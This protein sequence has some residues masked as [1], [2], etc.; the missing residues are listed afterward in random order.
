MVKRKSGA[1]RQSRS[2][3]TY[4]IGLGCWIFSGSVAHAQ[5]ESKLEE[6]EKR[7]DDMREEI[8]LEREFYEL[9][10]EGLGEQLDDLRAR[11]QSGKGANAFNPSITVFGN[12]LARADDRFVYLDD[13]PSAA[14]LDD[15]P[16]FR[17]LEVDFR[18]AIDPYS[19]AVV[20]LSVASEVPGEFSAG[21]EEAYV[22]LKRLP[23]LDSAPL[24]LKLRA[25]RFRPDFGRFNQ[26]HLHDLPQ[27]SY[28]RALGAYL[29]PEG[30]VGEGLG[31]NFFLPAGGEKNSLEADLQWL[32]G[33]GLPVADSQGGSQLA[34]LGHLKFFHELSDASTFELGSSLWRSDSDH[35]L[36]GVDATYKWK[37]LLQGESNSFLL[38]GELFRAQT[39]DDV[40]GGHPTGYYLWTQYQ[41]TRSFYLG[42]RYDESQALLDS[43]QVTRTLG[44]FATHYTSE[45]LRTRWGYEHIESD[46]SQLDGRDSIL[47]ELNF[48]FGSHPTEPYWVSK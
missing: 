15:R 20:I 29:G 24:G 10:I 8:D 36:F 43:D 21:V 46:L 6:L 2:L 34:G 38:G 31:A 28:P 45:F 1:W 17:E 16:Q 33:G 3:G 11:G 25:G 4:C 5:D 13:D 23:V 14:R 40:A 32:R 30:Y 12:M 22:D 19:D 47:F 48:I 9:E 41:F 27:S 7:M 44:L 18:S 42:L 35:S 26:I 39:Q 37:P